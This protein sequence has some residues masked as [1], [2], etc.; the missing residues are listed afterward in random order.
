[1]KDDLEHLFSC[2]NFLSAG[3]IGMHHR[4]SQKYYTCNKVGLNTFTD[5]N[6]HSSQTEYFHH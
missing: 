6:Y 1:M 2:L 5:L 4:D 3:I